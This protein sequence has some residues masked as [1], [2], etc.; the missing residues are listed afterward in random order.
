MERH[1]ELIETNAPWLDRIGTE[2]RDYCWGAARPPGLHQGFRISVQCTRTLTVVYGFDGQLLAR[3]DLPGEALFAAGWGQVKNV[4]RG[5]QPVEQLRVALN[6]E[7]ILGRNIAI[8]RVS[9]QW[10]PNEMLSRP[11]GM[12]GTPPCAGSRYH[13]TCRSVM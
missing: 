1:F 11:A 8:R 3:L 6:G 4:R 2:L 9:P 12:E 10:W 7:E 13:Q 5:R